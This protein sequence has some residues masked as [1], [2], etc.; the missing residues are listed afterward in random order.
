MTTE[1]W[2]GRDGYARRIFMD[3]HSRY[4]LENYIRDELRYEG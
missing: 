2:L 1:T 3:T 4:R